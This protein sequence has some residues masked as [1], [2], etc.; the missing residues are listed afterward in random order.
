[1]WR[2]ASGRQ[3][4][5]LFSVR[6]PR[7]TIRLEKQR[8]RCSKSAGSVVNPADCTSRADRAE[9]AKENQYSKRPLRPTTAMSR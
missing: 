7:K 9:F 8:V 6:W 2:M 1:M 3:Q 5:R 4:D